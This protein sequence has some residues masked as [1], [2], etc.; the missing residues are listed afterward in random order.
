MFNLFL[1][2]IIMIKNLFL[3][4]LMLS[5]A[6]ISQAQTIT[7]KDQQS[8]MPLEMVSIISEGQYNYTLTNAQGQ[9]NISA[10]EHSKKIQ[11]RMISYKTITLTYAELK[12]QKFVILLEPSNLNLGEVVVSG[13]RWRQNF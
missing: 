8:K 7:I 6:I 9:A 2:K 1:N 4:W 5:C 12:A 13:T 10:F 3:L 11:I